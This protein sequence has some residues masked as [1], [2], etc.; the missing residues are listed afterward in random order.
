MLVLSALSTCPS[1]VAAYK[2]TA[3]PKGL[4]NC[5]L[6]KLTTDEIV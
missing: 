1:K 2:T 4:I 3:K 6:I 5:V